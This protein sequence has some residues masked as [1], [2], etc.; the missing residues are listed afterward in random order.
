M[1]RH[2]SLILALALILAPIAAYAAV[3]VAI[4]KKT[5]W[6]DTRVTIARITFDSSYPTGGESLTAANL[7]LTTLYA[8]MPMSKDGYTFQYD[9]GNSKL[10]AYSIP[11]T[12]TGDFTGY[13]PL[14]QVANTT[15]LSGVDSVT[16][17]AVGK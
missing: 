4:D 6:G 13:L 12:T 16:V 7:G 8:V 2:L 1:K 14:Y 5:V 17:I 3:T 9:L 11:D 10:L 15:D